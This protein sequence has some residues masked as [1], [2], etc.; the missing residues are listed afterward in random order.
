M[1]CG[2]AG[3]S[4]SAGQHSDVLEVEEAQ[5][6]KNC[7]SLPYGPEGRVDKCH[8]LVQGCQRPLGTASIMEI[9]QEWD[10]AQGIKKFHSLHDG[11]CHASQIA[12]NKPAWQAQI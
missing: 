2:C 3:V 10:M 5:A 7:H 4:V 1:P 6:M 8:V 9:N 12:Q 11:K